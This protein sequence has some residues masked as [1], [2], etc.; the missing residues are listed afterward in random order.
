MTFEEWWEAEIG[1]NILDGATKDMIKDAHVYKAMRRAYNGGYDKGWD[2]AQ[3]QENK[4][5]IYD[6]RQTL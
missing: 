3:E 4:P 6:G 2:D 5:G 1:Y